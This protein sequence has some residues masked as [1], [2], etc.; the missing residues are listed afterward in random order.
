MT[1]TRAPQTCA[2]APAWCACTRPATLAPCAARPPDAFEPDCTSCIDGNACTN[3][4]TCQSGVCTG[5]PNIGACLDVFNCDKAK[6]TQGTPK[7]VPIT[8]LNLADEFETGNFDV[9]K[10]K[11]LCLPA[12]KDGSTIVDPDTHLE[13]YII[14]VS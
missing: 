1:P 7:W 6:T 13:S 11:H 4:D 2:T 5:T 12:T 3:P 14:K 9:K 10:P 8:G